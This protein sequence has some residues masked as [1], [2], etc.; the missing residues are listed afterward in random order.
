MSPRD[1]RHF[2]TVAKTA[3]A[4][5]ARPLGYAPAGRTL[6]VRPHLAGWHEAFWL[7]TGW[8]G[9]DSFGI[10][11]GIIASDFH[12]ALPLREAPLLLH[13]TLRNAAGASAFSRA[14]RAQIAASAEAFARLYPQQAEPWFAAFQSWQDIANEYAQRQSRWLD[15]ARLG[16]YSEFMPPQALYGLLLLKAGSPQAA[17]G[18]LQESRRLLMSSKKR[19]DWEETFLQDV[20][21]ALDGLPT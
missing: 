11:Y 10:G 16:Q 7:D 2:S 1:Y 8:S 12:P 14:S 6:F 19:E 21:C 18:W 17:S 13:E 5:V 3:F 15:E 9:G 20:N 4:K